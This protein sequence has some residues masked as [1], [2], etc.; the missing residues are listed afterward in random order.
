VASLKWIVSRIKLP[1]NQQLYL[2]AL[3]VGVISGLVAVVFECGLHYFTGLILVDVA[4][5]NISHPFGE[6]S[7]RFFHFSP[8]GDPL[9]WAMLIIPALGGLLSGYIVYRFCPE[10]GGT[11]TD[12]MIDAFHRKV[13]KISPLV[14][15]VK[16]ITTIIT[17]ATG[18]STGKEG[19]VAQI[20]AG[21]GSIIAVKLGIG[22]RS[23]R[24]LLLAGTAAGLGAIFQAPLGGALTA[25]EILY[26]E[27]IES[28]SLIPCVISSITAYAIFGSIFG[29]SHVFLLPGAETM[30]FDPGELLIFLCMGVIC[31]WVGYLYVKCFYGMRDKFFNK[32]KLKPYY[33]TALGGLLLGVLGFFY[34]E[35]FGSGFGYIQEIIY[36]NSSAITWASVG[37]FCII[38]LFKIVGTSLTI[39]SGGSGGVFAPSLF[40]GSMIGAAVGGAFHLLLP[41]MV[42][43]PFGAFVVVGMC[44]FFAGVAHAPIAAVIMVCEMTG[45]YE[46]LAPLMLVS[47]LAIML[48]QKWSIYENQ[49]KNKFF[50]KA[51]VGDMTINVLQEL[52]VS[53]LSPYRQVGIISSHTLFYSGEKFGQKIHAS[54]LVLVD[55]DDIYA[56]MVSLRDVHFDTS[57][58]FIC[59]LITLEDIMTPNI[60]TVTPEH[61]LHEALEILMRSEFDKVPVLRSQSDPE[62]HLLGYISY[63]DIL[64]KYHEIVNPHR[65]A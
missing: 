48:S 21:V 9:R 16:G 12:A 62:P 61:N 3:L 6:N 29:F 42:Q 22:V 47:V 26:R 14:P 58:L 36:L 2:L 51:H 7:A 52:K 46:L 15:L 40:I 5:L 4:N 57:D 11:G 30:G 56:G 1:E 23:R 39:G 63:N 17:M 35:I 64:S 19:P 13:G 28:D 54:D 31:S 37:T 55:H 43:S 18:G 33:R 49:V 44:S 20:G 53:V 45:G 10:A 27:D 34:M 50:S 8:N 60:R 38:G 65:V 59:N 25:V 32:L 41:D 24:T